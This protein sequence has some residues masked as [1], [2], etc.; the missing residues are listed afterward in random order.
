MQCRND[1]KSKY[2]GTEPSPKGLGYCAHVE[3][4]GTVMEGLDGN[5]WRISVASNGSKRWTKVAKTIAITKIPS[6]DDDDD[7]NVDDDVDDETSIIAENCY[8]VQ[9]IMNMSDHI[10]KSIIPTHPAYTVRH[11]DILSTSVDEGMGVICDKLINLTN[12]LSFKAIPHPGSDKKVYDI[13]H[14]SHY[15][16]VPGKSIG[17]NGE[18]FKSNYKFEKRRHGFYLN[19]TSDGNDYKKEVLRRWLPTVYNVT[20]NAH[21]YTI[22]QKSYI[23]DLF[24]VEPE[25]LKKTEKIIAEV[26]GCSIYMWEGLLRDM[27]EN[28][29]KLTNRDLQIVPKIASYELQPGQTHE[30]IWHVEGVQPEHIIMSSIL[31]FQDEIENASLEFRRDRDDDEQERMVEIPE[32][33]AEI[34]GDGQWLYKELGTLKTL[35]NHMY[36]WVNACQHKLKPIRN[37][38]NTV[39]KRSFIAFFLVDPDIKIT[40]TADIPPQNQYW[41]EE[42]AQSEM[43]HLMTERKKVKIMLNKQIEDEISYCEH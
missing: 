25:L 11:V 26:L 36:A 6:V 43:E 33:N 10:I 32:Q 27:R 41:T 30:G 24:G 42:V 16:Y 20:E 13:I 28:N 23:N 31:Y 9:I 14:P 39:K 34:I 35:E 2:D 37:D 40:S 38:S 1:P 21:K 18:V 19:N 17:N 3:Q 15:P 22:T 4:A 5:H 7:D 29:L 8:D 12:E